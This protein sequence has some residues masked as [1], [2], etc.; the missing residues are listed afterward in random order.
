MPRERV[1]MTFGM[2]QCMLGL[3]P[4]T[5]AQVGKMAHGGGRLL[6]PPSLPQGADM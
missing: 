6:A 4:V 3:V 1:A 5:G 2:A